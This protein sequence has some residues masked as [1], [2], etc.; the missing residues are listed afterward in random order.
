MMPPKA[1]SSPFCTNASGLKKDLNG[2]NLPRHSK[3]LVI[4]SSF[5]LRKA[6]QK[7]KMSPQGLASNIALLCKLHPLSVFC[8]TVNCIIKCHA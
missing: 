3:F 7:L 8:L 6:V 5:L 4:C 1:V 2:I